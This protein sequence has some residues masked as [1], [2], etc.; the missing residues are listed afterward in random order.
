MIIVILVGLMVC[1]FLACKIASRS[2]NVD[3]S[4][5]TQNEGTD[6]EAQGGGRL[7]TRTSLV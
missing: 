4:N 7:A 6:F 5:N 3:P 1:A 2:D